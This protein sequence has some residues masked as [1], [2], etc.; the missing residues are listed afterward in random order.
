[1]PHIQQTVWK[2]AAK[3]WLADF[4]DLNCKSVWQYQRDLLVCLNGFP[5]DTR[6]YQPGLRDFEGFRDSVFAPLFA[7]E[8][9][10]LRRAC[11][12]LRNGRGSGIK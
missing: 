5:A 2:V 1:M 6:V 12:H 10:G 11:D 7:L 4:P 9:D 3:F 8:S